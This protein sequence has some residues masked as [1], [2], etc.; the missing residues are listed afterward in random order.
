MSKPASEETIN[1]LSDNMGHIIKECFPILRNCIN[2]LSKI[3]QMLGTGCVD[4]NTYYNYR[5]VLELHSCV[6]Y[7]IIEI[8]CA[9]RADIH[10]GITIE[11]RINLKYIVFIA[12]EFFKAV[13][14]SKN[15][16]SLWDDVSKHI[17]SL[18]IEGMEMNEI[19]QSIEQYDK[20]YYSQDKDNRDVS[21][22]YDFDLAKLYDYLVNISEEKEARRLCDFMAIVQPL[23]NLLNLYSSIIVIQVKA[24]KALTLSDSVF[25]ATLFDNLKEKLYPLIGDSLQHFAG[26]LDKNM[27]TYSIV[28]KLPDN[29]IA[30]FDDSCIERIIAIRDYSKTAI[31]LHYIYLD[32][33]SV[34]RGYLQSESY[35]E[36]RWNLIRINL[37]IYE[38]WKKI[39]KPQIGKEKSLWG[40]YIYNPLI[41]NDDDA[42]KEEV[43]S[44]NSLLDSYN[45]NKHI[46]NI[47]H[48]YIHLMERKKNNLS[49]LLDELLKLNPYYELNKSL[50]F[51]KLLSRIIKLNIKSM[52]IVSEADSSYNRKK[53]QEPFNQIKSKILESNMA[54]D[55]K[56]ELLNTIEDGKTKIM[57]LFN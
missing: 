11:K 51:L 28:E 16:N 52:H 27:H 39:Y 29:I 46:E 17:F 45:E 36:K 44:V 20:Q 40:Q 53:I 5:K 56:I 31:L 24:E 9:F 10:S 22:H 18:K 32:L 49:D 3:K 57:S 35:L 43:K 8:A 2:G 14:V 33:G 26:C 7:V 34:I 41:Q 42:V 15:N 23:H 25:D 13:F 12:S 21:V 19:Q 55:K 47:R 38:G 4:N 37:I 50:V 6:L 1:N 30:T 54:E 48:K